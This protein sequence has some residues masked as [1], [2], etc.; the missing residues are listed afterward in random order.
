MKI[1][2][3]LSIGLVLTG[4]YSCSNGEQITSSELSDLGD[5]TKMQLVVDMPTTPSSRTKT[6]ETTT[7]EGT[8]AEN[9]ASKVLVAVFNE[10]KSPI[11]TYEQPLINMEGT[12]FK[13]QV[14]E[15][16]QLEVGKKY[17]VYLFVN[18]YD[19]LSEDIIDG[20]FESDDVFDVAIKKIASPNNFFMSNANIV[21][22]VEVEESAK[23]KA[24]PYI[25]KAEVERSVARFDYI[26]KATNNEYP[27]NDNENVTAEMTTYKLINT[28]RSFYNLKRVNDGSLE[29]QITLGGNETIDNYVVDADWSKKTDENLS[30]EELFFSALQSSSFMTNNYKNLEVSDSYKPLSYTTENTLPKLVQNKKGLATAIVFKSKLNFNSENYGVTDANEPVYVWNNTFYGVYDNLPVGVKSQ[31]GEERSIKELEKAG[32]TGYAYEEGY[33]YPMYYVYYNRH[34]DNKDNQVTGP[35]E[36]A[37]VRNNVYKLA[38]TSVKLFGHPNDPENPNPENP[39]PKPEIPTDPIETKHIYMDVECKVLPWTVRE[40]DIEF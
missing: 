26:S 20:K 28:A 9:N 3:L 27:V 4:L 29:G 7:E 16:D 40:N 11:A 5:G 6:G 2:K 1:K 21:Q 34:N 22:L 38:I 35:M 24:T 33:G 30:Y 15:A 18:P 23:N 25:I 36:Y 13:T 10:D 12:Q 19:N 8:E 17:Y 14:F 39:D 31:I 32:V 37:V